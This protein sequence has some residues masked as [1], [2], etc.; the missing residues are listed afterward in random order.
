MFSKKKIPLPA[1]W[2]VAFRLTSIPARFL[3]THQYT[4]LSCSFLLCATRRK[5]SEPSDRMTFCDLAPLSLPLPAAAPLGA[6]FSNSPSLYHSIVGS[7][8]PSALQPNVIGSF[9][10][11]VMSVGCSVILG[12]R[13]WPEK[14]RTYKIETFSPH[15]W[16]VGTAPSPWFGKGG[17]WI[18]VFVAENLLLK[19][20]KLYR[21]KLLNTC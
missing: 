18:K 2:S 14:R 1:T 3:A 17:N 11:T 16:G 19:I 10:G 13:Y 6:I 5:N 9:F 20:L 12:F 15:S 4:P 7:G 8:R 21:S